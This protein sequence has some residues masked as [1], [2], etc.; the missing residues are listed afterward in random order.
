MMNALRPLHE[1]IEAGHTTMKEESFNQTYFKE[2]RDAYR[3][4]SEFDRTGDPKEV[5]QVRTRG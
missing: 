2:L 4:C 5:N 3:H 1:K